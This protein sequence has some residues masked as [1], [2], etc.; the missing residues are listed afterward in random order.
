MQVALCQWLLIHLFK[1]NSWFINLFVRLRRNK[2]EIILI[3]F[4]KVQHKWSAKWCW[5][6]KKM[7]KKLHINYLNNLKYLKKKTKQFN[8]FFFLIFNW[9]FNLNSRRWKKHEKYWI[10]EQL[11]IKLTKQAKFYHIYII[12]IL[13]TE[14]LFNYI[15]LLFTRLASNRI[16]RVNVRKKVL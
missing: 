2:Y 16:K 3:F 10:S 7:N 4:Y 15:L 6:R 13:Y 14:K 8:N 5:M 9:L 12:V 11:D 1:R